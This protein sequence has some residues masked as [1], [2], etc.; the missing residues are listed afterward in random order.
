MSESVKLPSNLKNF[1][2]RQQPNAILRGCKGEEK[3]YF[4]PRREG[5]KE[6]REEEFSPMLKLRRTSGR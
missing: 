5:R 6:G 4:L 3:E 2:S 1:I